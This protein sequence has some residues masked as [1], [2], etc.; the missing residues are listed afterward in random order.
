MNPFLYSISLGLG[1]YGVQLARGLAVRDRVAIALDEEDASELETAFPSFFREGGFKMISVSHFGGL[2][3]RKVVQA[4]KTYREIVRHGSDVIHLNLG[5]LLT[6]ALP[7][8]WL[9][10]RSGIPLVATVHDPWFHAGDLLPLRTTWLMFKALEWCSQIIV[11]GEGLKQELIE[12][13]GFDER[14]ISVIP[15]GNYDIYLHA[16]GAS[17]PSEPTPGQVLFF[18]RMKKYKG[19]DVLLEAAPMVAEKVKDLKIVL[20]GKGDELDRLESRFRE[21]PWF[22]IHKGWI[23]AAQIPDLFSSSSAVVVPYVEATQSGILHVAYS[24]GR[25]VVATRVGAISESLTHGKEGLLVPPADARALAQAMIEVLTDK[26]MAVRMGLAA[27]EKAG[28]ELDWTGEISERTRGIYEKARKMKREN[29]CYPGIGARARWLR[30]MDS[31]RR[32]QAHELN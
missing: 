29:L 17:Q 10:H 20:A 2:D 16:S 19:L 11:H 25:P 32:Q 6:E 27:R 18:G 22:E 14:M 8:L 1:I 7:V 4:W 31:Y 24:L 13:L 12:R 5:G 28:T 21:Q 26:E 23:D 3:P 15:H 30:I 9:C